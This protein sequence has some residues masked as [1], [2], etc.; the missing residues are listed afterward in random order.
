MGILRFHARFF[1]DPFF[2]ER[3]RTKQHI[4]PGVPSH[5]NRI[6]LRGSK[7]VVENSAQIILRQ[8]CDTFMTF[9]AEFSMIQEGVFRMF[10]L[11]ETHPE[12]PTCHHSWRNKPTDYQ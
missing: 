5:L 10:E 6:K 8:L 11:V 9:T 7:V 12:I 3:E 4:V 2:W 1:L